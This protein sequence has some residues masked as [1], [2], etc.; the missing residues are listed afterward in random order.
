MPEHGH[1]LPVGLVT[2]GVRGGRDHRVPGRVGQLGD[3]LGRVAGVEAGWDKGEKK[4][5]SLNAVCTKSGDVAQWLKTL[6]ATSFL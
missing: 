3:H 5:R 1:G 6:H 2:L 4:C